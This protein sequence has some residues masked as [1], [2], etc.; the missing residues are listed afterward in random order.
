MKFE[1][2]S[3]SPRVSG[4]KVLGIALF[5]DFARSDLDVIPS[6]LA[7]LTWMSMPRENFKAK[8]DSVLVIPLADGEV[9][10]IIIFGLGKRG[11]AAPDDYRKAAY[12]ITRHAAAKGADTVA[13]AIPGAEDRTISRCIGEG[14]ALAAY[15][16][17]KYHEPDPEDVFAVP[18]YIDVLRGNVDGLEE[19]RIMA[20]GQ[21][22]ARDLA[23]EPGNVI[24]P[25]VLE[26]SARALA[27]E[28][29]LAISV[30]HADELKKRG[31]NALLSVGSGSATPP[32]LIH[33]TYEP[34]AAGSAKPAKSSIAIVGKGLT[35]DSG[36]LSLKPA[37]SMLT[38]KGDK[39][40]ACVA[41]G[42]IK[43]AS[44]LGLPIKLHVIIGAAENMP[45]GSAYRPDD[46]IKAYNGKTI[47]VNNTDA[48]G[49]LTLADAL[50]YACEQKPDA[51]IDIATLTG[52]CAVALGDTTAGLFSNDDKLAQE[53]L[54]ASA[55]SGEPFWRLPMTDPNL[56]KKLKSPIADLVN[57]AGRYGGAITAA[58]FLENFV[59]KG[60]PWCHLDIA[61]TDFVKEPYSYYI[62][63]A[64][65]FGIRSILTCLI[66]RAKDGAI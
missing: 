41:L 40:G 10:H 58:M 56:R 19:G 22:Y 16:F 42:T 18:A 53:M 33:L 50:A 34:V 47:E 62:K 60:I 7:V 57:S 23:N 46:V 21:C 45:S 5:E 64:S 48:E 59:E 12:S 14:A 38:M 26:D 8:K 30:L 9:R 54:D 63:G 51:V 4:R 15:R 49:R 66:G 27:A 37:D 36:G 17:E 2:L 25:A 13:L 65:A 61:A 20:N 11:E 6:S 55:A 28:K 43:A 44:E 32:R 35:F 29:G 39:T 52:A 1:V 31:M 24:N 3:D